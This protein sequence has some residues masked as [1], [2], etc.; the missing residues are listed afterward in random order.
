MAKTLNREREDERI[1]E[2]LRAEFSRIDLN[3]DG[4]ITFDEI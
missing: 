2:Q 4:S 1:M 3:R